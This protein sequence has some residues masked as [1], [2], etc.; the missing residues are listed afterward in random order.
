METRE[1][2]L[3]C[4]CPAGLAGSSTT[5]TRVGERRFPSTLRQRVRGSPITQLDKAEDTRNTRDS[6]GGSGWKLPRC[7][8]QL[9]RRQRAATR[10]WRALAFLNAGLRRVV[11]LQPAIQSAIVRGKVTLRTKHMIQRGQLRRRAALFLLARRP[12]AQRCCLPRR[13]LARSR[14]SSLAYV[15]RRAQRILQ[16]S[17]KTNWFFVRKKSIRVLSGSHVDP[18]PTAAE[19]IDGRRRPRK[20]PAATWILYRKPPKSDRDY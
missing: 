5:P 1:H 9:R 13:R 11:R 15:L 17:S 2:G 20:R 12:S 10:A 4:W 14:L 16:G 19:D 7:A 6:T 18:R 3:A 8:R